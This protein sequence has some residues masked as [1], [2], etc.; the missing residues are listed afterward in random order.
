MQE[1]QY[2]RVNGQRSI[3]HP[4]Y[5]EMEGKGVSFP[6]FPR[7]FAFSSK[8][9]RETD[10]AMPL[11]MEIGPIPILTE[12]SFAGYSGINTID[13]WSFIPEYQHDHAPFQIIVKGANYHSNPVNEQRDEF[14]NPPGQFVHESHIIQSAACT[15]PCLVQGWAL[16]F[17]R[18][19]KPR[20]KE[21]II[22]MRNKD[23]RLPPIT[24]NVMIL[25]QSP[26]PS[27]MEMLDAPQWLVIPPP[28]RYIEYASLIQDLSVECD[29]SYQLEDS[30]IIHRLPRENV[31]FLSYFIFVYRPSG[32]VPVHGWF[33]ER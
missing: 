29:V 7:I 8:I 21:I 2:G 31:H 3:V 13:I 24:L 1:Q 32:G 23:G 6:L 20:V 26:F 15:I 22:A 16:K 11:F 10:G 30:P 19:V 17:E 27:G 4:N 9:R 28:S 14:P 12:G 18:Q 25:R 5:A 33:S